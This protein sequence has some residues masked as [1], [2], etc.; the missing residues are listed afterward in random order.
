MQWTF[1]YNANYTTVQTLVVDVCPWGEGR[2]VVQW[3]RVPVRHEDLAAGQRQGQ[4][5]GLA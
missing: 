3:P 1:Y 5:E 2:I 4:P